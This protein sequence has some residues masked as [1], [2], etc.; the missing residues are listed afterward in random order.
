MHLKLKRII[1][2]AKDVVLLAGFYKKMFGIKDGYIAGDKKWAE[3]NTGSTSIAFHNG[4][5]K[6]SKDGHPK[7]VFYAKDVDKARTM[8]IDKGVN[9]GRVITAEE[10]RL[11][12]GKDPEG[13]V[14]QIS[15]R[16]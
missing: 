13:N 5:K 15:N 14:F 2:F 8:L 10:L 11:C 16:K 7:L 9:M 12:N 1:I 3:L 6:G 4:G